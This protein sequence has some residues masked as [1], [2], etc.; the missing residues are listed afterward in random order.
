MKTSYYPATAHDIYN[1]FDQHSTFQIRANF[2]DTY[3]E[4]SLT[5]WHD[6]LLIKHEDRISGNGKQY[7]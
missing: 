2:L 5:E 7:C 1:N 6:R 4:K 3:L